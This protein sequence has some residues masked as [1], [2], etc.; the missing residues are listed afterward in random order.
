[1]LETFLLHAT[2]LRKVNLKKLSRGWRIVWWL[3]LIPSIHL[4]VVQF[5]EPHSPP[6]HPGVHGY[7][8]PW[9]WITYPQNCTKASSSSSTEFNASC[10]RIVSESPH[11]EHR[12]QATLQK[13]MIK[14]K[15]VCKHGDKV[16]YTLMILVFDL[17][18]L[19]GL[20]GIWY[21]KWNK[22]HNEWEFF[23]LESF[24]LSL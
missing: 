10:F 1:M 23:S 6:K 3:G 24:H 20:I 5:S 4:A 7:H 15:L 9:G 18:L 17:A 11:P 19:C 12:S 21:L 13:N 14:T 8:E 22:I 2:Q 16:T